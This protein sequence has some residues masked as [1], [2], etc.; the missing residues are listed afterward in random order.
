[1]V[2]VGS[3]AQADSLVARR[4]QMNC[5]LFALRRPYAEQRRTIWLHD[6]TERLTNVRSGLCRGRLDLPC[7]IGFFHQR[8]IFQRR[9]RRL[10]LTE[11][12]PRRIARV[13]QRL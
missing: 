1:M 8:A 10:L 6:G 11:M 3:D 12:W 13:T 2:A 4:G 7:R 5:N 9:R